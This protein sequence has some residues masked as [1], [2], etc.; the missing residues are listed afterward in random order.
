MS[1]DTGKVEAALPIGSGNDAVRFDRGQVFASCKDGSF[2][3]I[4][5]KDS[6]FEVEQTIETAYGAKT[7]G[8]DESTQE[9]FL[10]TAETAPATAGQP[11]QPKAGAFE[12]LVLRRN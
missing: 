10:P 12:I 3:V 2:T 11:S 9:V 5:E 6:Q 7:M 8:L 4:G 1:T